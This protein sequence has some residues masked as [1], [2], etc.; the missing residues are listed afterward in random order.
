MLRLRTLM[1]IGSLLIIN[2][3]EAGYNCPSTLHYNFAV[4]PESVSISDSSKTVTI[5]NN[6]TVLINNKPVTM[7]TKILQQATRLQSQIRQELPEIK[8]GVQQKLAQGRVTL[9]N[10]ITQNLGSESHLHQ[11]L[12][13]LQQQL[14]Q[15]FNKIISQKNN[16][17]VFNYQAIDLARK[18]T[19][20]LLRHSLGAMVQDGLNESGSQALSSDGKFSF[21][22]A[23]NKL[24]GLQQS[25]QQQLEKDK[26]SFSQF[27][28][29]ICND[30]SSIEQQRRQLYQELN[31]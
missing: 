17:L 27:G 8:Q 25:M 22:D 7:T 20:T 13:T 31:L 9:D 28:Q 23:M 2:T 12:T 16:T 1:L 14:Q 19:E 24:A 3:A 4:D 29:K 11:S 5:D 15:Q 6:G 21:K 30:I 10:I 18:D 26:Q